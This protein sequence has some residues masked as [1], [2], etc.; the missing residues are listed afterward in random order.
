MRVAWYRLRATIKHRVPAYLGL[1]LIIGLLGGIAMASAAGA[2]RTQSS[3]PEFMQSTNPSDLTMAVYASTANGGPGSDLSNKIARLA[4]VKTVSGAIAPPLVP[5]AT[6]GAPRLDTLSTIVTVGS[7]NGLFSTQ[8]RLA[9]IA[10]R[11]AR[12]SDPNEVTL[13]PSAAKTFGV[14]VNSSLSLGLYSPAQQA[15]PGFGTPRVRPLVLVHAKVVGLVEINTQVLEDDVDRTY[16]FMFVTPALIHHILAVVHQHG[17]PALYA[18]QL[19]AKAPPLVKVERELIGVVPEGYTYE[20]HINSRITSQVEL[21][22]KPESVALGAFGGIAAL[23]CLVIAAQAISRLLRQDEEDFQIMQALGA[24]TSQSVLAG[25]LGVGGAVIAGVAIAI[26]LAIGLSPLAPLGP[27]RGVYPYSGF[28]VDWT[29]FTLGSLVIGLG[30][31]GVAAA[32]SVRAAHRRKARVT[33]TNSPLGVARNALSSRLPVAGALG[34]HFAL[35]SGRGRTSV[36][37]RSVLAGT[38]VALGLVVA[39]LT[40][41]SGLQTLV[42][43]PALY[44]WNWNYALDPT[45]NVP[46]IALSMLNRDHDVAAWSGAYYTDVQLDNQEVPILIEPLHAPVTPPVLDGHGV[47]QN[48]QIVLGAATLAMLHKHVGDTV[49]LSLGT[50]LDAPEYLAPRNLTIVGSATFPAIGYSTFV[51]EHTSMGTGALVSLGDFPRSF[52]VNSK[53]PVLDGP[54]LVFVRLRP[55]VTAKSGAANL[56]TIADAADK[57]FS[58]DPNAVGNGVAVLG[59]SRPVQIVNY[60]SIGST[61]IILAVGLAIGAIIALALTLASS[62]RRRRRDLAL[63]KTLGF[64]RRQL[65]AAVAWQATTTALIGGVVGIPLGVVAGRELWTLFARSIDAVPDPSVPV[66]SVILV[67]VGAIVFANLIATLPGRIAARTATATV[68]RAE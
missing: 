63:L 64:T 46:P 24:N 36:P 27:I 18:V 3:Y 65:A 57:V 25:L 39:T 2:R 21:A 58:A 26:G 9:P 49:S 10:G 68:L 33:E 38:A 43:R 12:S 19:T 35:D 47:E 42:A 20:F 11:I 23:A 7:L 29:I 41:S 48:N 30:L 55:G 59:V 62:V 60:R 17:A 40:F 1:A 66:L 45:N 15:L 54:E 13:T 50:P 4:G 32:L 52:S 31:G 56:Q 16:G 6:N 28:A 14:K 37:V 53:D 5:L 44:G 67:G 34:V 61:P 22:L 51:A 8:D